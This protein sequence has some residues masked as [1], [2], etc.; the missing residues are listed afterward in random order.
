MPTPNVIKLNRKRL[1]GK[2]IWPYLFLVPFFVIYLAFNFYPLIYSFIIS[3]N[4]WDGFTKPAFIGFKNY[5]DIF[6]RDPYFLKSIKNT[7]IFMAFDI[8][9]CVGGGIVM[10]AILNSKYLKAPDVFRWTTF[11]PYVTIPVAIGILFLLIFDW[12]MGLLNRILLSI[13][14]IREGINFLGVPALARGVTISMIFWKYL[15]YH[16]I[17]FNAGILSISHELY[18]AA[19]VDGASGFTKF[20]KITVPMLKPIL[21]FLLVMNIIWGFQ[22]FDEPKAMFSS[23]TSSGGSVASAGG[24]QRS[25][26]TAIWNLYDTSF[27]TQMQYGK[28][29]AIAYGLFLFILVSSLIVQVII[30]RGKSKDEG[31]FF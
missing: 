4:K 5:V 13:G 12:N 23:W 9:L 7:L 27:G 16:M 6:T 24:P 21:E 3:L 25:I 11:L 18:E 19:D 26:L 14:I 30:R 2:D 29:A 22:L 15:G 20:F 10:A 31:G 1:Q 8:P 17:F 28:G